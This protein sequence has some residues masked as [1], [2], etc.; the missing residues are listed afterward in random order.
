M[1]PGAPLPPLQRTRGAAKG[2]GAIPFSD[3]DQYGWKTAAKETTTY[4]NTSLNFVP[5]TCEDNGENIAIRVGLGNSLPVDNKIPQDLQALDMVIG[6]QVIAEKITS[7]HELED[8]AS[9][10]HNEENTAIGPRVPSK[11]NC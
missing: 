6:S 3:G 8:V 1:R 9:T 10:M 5:D 7:M 11:V 4:Q 2:T